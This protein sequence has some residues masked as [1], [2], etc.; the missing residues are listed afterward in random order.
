[1]ARMIYSAVTSLDGYV[2]DEA[3]R[4]DWTGPVDAEFFAYI[5]DRE[6]RNGTYL[7]GRRMYETMAVWDTPEVIPDPTPGMLEFV[8]IWQA[9]DKVVY[10][11]TLPSVS[12]ARA[13]LERTFDPDA[14]RGLKATATRDISVGG[15]GLAAHAIRAGLVDEFNLLIAPILLG[16]GTPYL[17]GDVRLDLEL[18]ESR[19]FENGMV[20][21]RYGPKG[22]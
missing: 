5:N 2:A 14:V 16:G 3:G 9:A 20:L 22:A 4:I 17:P 6:R 15:P 13:R 21:A 10:S 1:M 7:F 12:M 18:L 19:R 11:T 8:T